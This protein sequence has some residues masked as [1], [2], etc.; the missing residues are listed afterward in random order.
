MEKTAHNRPHSIGGNQTATAN[1]QRSLHSRENSSRADPVIR[2]ISIKSQQYGHTNTQ[3]IN[4]L[5]G[6]GLYLKRPQIVT[7]AG[8]G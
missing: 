3:A 8:I 1:I 5:T 2:A 7:T 6:T 4:C